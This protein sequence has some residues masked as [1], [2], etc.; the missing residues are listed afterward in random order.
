LAGPVPVQFRDS[1]VEALSER[2][3]GARLMVQG[4]GSFDRRGKLLRL[5]SVERLTSLEALDVPA[6]IDELRLLRN[7]WLDG[8]GLA[9][10][11]AGLSWFS[12][13]FDERFP[14]SLPLPYLY[15]TEEGGLRAE[16]SADEGREMSLDVDLVSHTAHWHSWQL[17]TDV[18]ESETLDL[19]AEDGWTRLAALVAG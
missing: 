6:R 11:G 7:G 10:A 15:P 8:H 14:D 12:Q 19:D 17:G 13:A 9:P 18:E 2:R 16:W 1:L 5:A 3:S 4:V